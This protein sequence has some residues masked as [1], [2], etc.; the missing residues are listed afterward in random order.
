MSES[1]SRRY[2][3][4]E[5]FIP[6]IIL[7]FGSIY[8]WWTLGELE[9]TPDINRLPA[10][11]AFLYNLGGRRGVTLFVAAVGA[12]LTLVGTCK[13]ISKLKNRG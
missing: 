2:P 11:I 3:W 7:L 9:Q 6:G 10:A 12:L 8:V 13:F 4:W 5:F 1:A